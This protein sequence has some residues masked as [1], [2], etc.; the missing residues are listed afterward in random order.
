VLVDGCR[1]A[2]PLPAPLDI[3]DPATR[4]AL[5]QVLGELADLMSV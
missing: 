4:A 3:P 2:D 5:D 1:R